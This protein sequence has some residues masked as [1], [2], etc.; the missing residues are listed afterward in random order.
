MV[1]N[2]EKAGVFAIGLGVVLVPAYLAMNVVDK[3]VKNESTAN[4]IKNILT[5][6]AIIGGIASGA[7]QVKKYELKKQNK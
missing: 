1:E 4:T 3:T 6:G 2:I 7:K 5:I